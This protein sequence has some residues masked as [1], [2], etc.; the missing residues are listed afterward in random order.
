MIDEFSER[1]VKDIGSKSIFDTIPLLKK[2]GIL[3][4][5]E[6]LDIKDAVT[7]IK[8]IAYENIETAL[9][10]SMSIPFNI[11]LYP[12]F[13]SCSLSPGGRII[14]FVDVSNF[15][16]FFAIEN[17]NLCCTIFKKDEVRFERIESVAFSLYKAE[18]V[19]FS[20]GNL[21]KRDESRKIEKIVSFQHILLLASLVGAVRKLHDLSLNFSNERKQ[22]G[23]PIIEYYAVWEKI[24]AMRS[25]YEIYSLVLGELVRQEFTPCDRTCLYLGY[26]LD[27][28]VGLASEAIQTHGGYGYMKDFKIEKIFR[29]I[30]ALSLL[31]SFRKTWSKFVKSNVRQ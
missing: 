31:F 16:A 9:F 20:S 13:Y 22:G 15:V 3:P 19:D 7:L 29:E 2:V 23:R 18:L 27:T 25:F 26:A 4:L 10:L 11:F 24:L 8:T 6:K 17:G 12:D 21:V 28:A 30:L 5:E 14:P 1:L